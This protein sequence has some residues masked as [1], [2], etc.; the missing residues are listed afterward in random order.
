VKLRSADPADKPRILSNVLSTENDRAYF[1]RLVPQLREIFATAPLSD[2]LRGELMP[3]PDVR[4]DAQIDAW[5]RSACNTALHP[6]GTC[7]M[8]PASD[9]M[10]VVDARLRMHGVEGL[11]VADAA[12]MPRIVGGNTNAACIMIGEKAAAMIAQDNGLTTGG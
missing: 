5:A 11:R 8:G 2:V 4:T 7:A 12:I 3:G 1:R 6:V 10:A 9:P